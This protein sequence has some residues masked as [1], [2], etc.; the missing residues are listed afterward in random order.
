MISSSK[1]KDVQPNTKEMKELQNLYN[2]ND[3]Y[4]V[5]IKTKELLKKYKENI[6]LQNIL[7]IALSVQWKS[8]DAIKIFDKIIEK[9]SDHYF[10]YNNKGNALKDLGK[11]NEAKDCYKQSI[12]VNPK[13]LEAYI[14][15]GKTFLDFNRIEDAASTFRRALK[16]DPK[17]TQLH[18]YLS[19]VTKYESVN[20]H[21]KEMEKILTNSN[22]TKNQEM[23]I[24][25]ALGKAY[26][27]INLDDKAFLF[28]EKGNF[29]KKQEINYSIDYQKKI[30][31]TIKKNFKM[32]LFKKIK[33]LENINEKLIFIVGMPRS[34]TTL[35]Q[36]IISAHP[37]VLAIGESNLLS[38][39]IEKT[40]FTENASLKKN[41][42][43]CDNFLFIKLGK[44]YIKNINQFSP[45]NRYVLVKDLRNFFWLGFIKIIFPNAKI[46]HTIRNPLDNCLS[47]FKNYF[48]GGVDFSYD[49]KDL[50]KYY[51]LYNEVMSFW[52]KILPNYYLNIYYEDLI[53]NPKEQI[54]KILKHSNLE[55][56]ENCMKFY[57][58]K[59]FLTTGTNSINVHRPIYKTS[60]EYW[61]KYE[62]HLKPLVE[63]IKI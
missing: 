8:T 1:Q 33:Y 9:K 20:E 13:Y 36:Q 18:R 43:D 61:K 42:E 31:E 30:F 14:N 7:G 52:N 38:N 35:V 6:E 21:I 34:G 44:D 46:I 11:L 49:L 59:N 23:H 45:N 19:Q 3:Y 55:W 28:W 62:K 54:K 50:G 56:Y 24:L 2:L 41:F 5:E 39:E 37:K 12:N 51:N 60:M 57:K 27:D 58:N 4:A 32:H 40:F 53:N 48:V 15:L 16:I 29:I 17:N 63:E 22:L 25:F 47:L 26:E 10:A